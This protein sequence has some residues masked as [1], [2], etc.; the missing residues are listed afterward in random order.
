MSPPLSSPLEESE[1]WA[2]LQF[3][4]HQELMR[5]VMRWRRAM[6]CDG[7]VP[8]RFDLDGPQPSITGLAYCGHG[9]PDDWEFVFLLPPE[10]ARTRAAIDWASLMPAAGTTGW[11]SPHPDE[12]RLV[13]DPSGAVPDPLSTG[14]N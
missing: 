7:L 10:T 2:R 12:K 13:I 4:V 1:F 8:Q 6:W 9:R 5:F 3:T 14:S 11:L